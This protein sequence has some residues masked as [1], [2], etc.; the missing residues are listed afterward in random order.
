MPDSSYKTKQR[1]LILQCLKQNCDKAYTVDEIELMLKNTG[2]C[3]G[4]TTVYR[5][6]NSLAQAGSVR[7]F[8]PDGEKS[9]TYQFIE[10]SENC[11]M[12][13]HL[14]CVKCGKLIHLECDIVDDMCS[15]IMLNHGFCV[16]KSKTTVLGLCRQCLESEEKDETHRV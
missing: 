4:R 15:H 14:K 9:A 7:R 2:N 12:H 16:D 11:K 13:I 1:S 6:I 5:Y 10:H 3:I 8:I